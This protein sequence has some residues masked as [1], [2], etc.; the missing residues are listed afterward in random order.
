MSNRSRAVLFAA[1]VVAASA[2]ALTPTP[3]GAQAAAS[4]AAPA[5]AQKA[6]PTARQLADLCDTCAVVT[7]IKTEKRKGKAT[8]AGTAGGAVVGGVVGNKVGDGGVLATGAGAVAGA[9]LGREIEKQVRRHKVWVTTV[10]TKDGKS[11]NVEATAD[12]GVKVGDV[13]RIDAGRIVR[14]SAAK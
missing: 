6:G 7:A 2:Q 5:V 10:T 11:Q 3:A 13:V 9:V 8:A 12:P 1:L 14:P 4:A